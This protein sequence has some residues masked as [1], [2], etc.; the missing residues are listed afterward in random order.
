MIDNSI[1]WPNGARCAVAMTWDLDA[2]SGLNDYH[3]DRADRLVASQSLTRYGP[4][5]AM[6][7][8][9]AICRRFD[10]HQTFFVPGWCAEQYPGAVEL[11]LKHDHE[12]APVVGR[13]QD[14]IVIGL[15]FPASWH[16]AKFPPDRSVRVPQP[17][18]IDGAIM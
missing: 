6:P 8:I 11:I 7:R 2:D 17:A 3:P 5:I 16:D 1:T 14:A 9:V 15:V 13:H 4:T 12:L 10:L 18:G